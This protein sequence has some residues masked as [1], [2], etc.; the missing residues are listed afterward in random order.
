M[1]QHLISAGCKTVYFFHRPDSAY[2]V[3]LRI[4]G[5]RAALENAGLNF[6]KSNI[7][8]GEPDDVTRIREMNIIPFETGIICGNDSTAASLISGLESIGLKITSD[9]LVA[10]F[11]NM[12][13][14]V[15]LKYPLT[16]Y[17]QPCEAITESSVD[18]IFNKL[19]IKNSRPVTVYLY[20]DVIQRAST[21][22]VH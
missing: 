14:S 12:K 15:H 8:C 9:V 16:T 17:Q 4:D 18:L 22:F 10:G 5:V 3:N 11:D 1:A 2:S 20:G 19:S 7:V 13:Y 6:N 21:V